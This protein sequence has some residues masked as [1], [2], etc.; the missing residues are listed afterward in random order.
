MAYILEPLWR[1]EGH[2]FYDTVCRNLSLYFCTHCLNS[3]GFYWVVCW[4]CY[5]LLI[6]ISSSLIYVTLHYQS[7]T[8]I[9]LT[10]LCRHFQHASM[11]LLVHVLDSLFGTYRIPIFSPYAANLSSTRELM[12]LVFFRMTSGVFI[13]VTNFVTLRSFIFYYRKLL[14]FWSVSIRL[15]TKHTVVKV[16]I[17]K[18]WRGYNWMKRYIR[19][20]G[21]WQ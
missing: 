18:H 14:Y 20:H 3:R 1:M 5:L 2:R 4:W 12:A 21:L 9:A 17:R 16:Y 8:R 13:F 19:K 10:N 15:A 6:L 7:R 11:C